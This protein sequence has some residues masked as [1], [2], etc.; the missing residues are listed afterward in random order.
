METQPVYTRPRWGFNSLGPYHTFDGDT[1]DVL[2]HTVL[3]W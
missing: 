3:D 1:A 2:L